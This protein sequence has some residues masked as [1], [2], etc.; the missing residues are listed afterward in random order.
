[1]T[2]LLELAELRRKGVAAETILK[3]FEPMVRFKQRGLLSRLSQA[4]PKL[5]D[6]LV[7]QA[8]AKLLVSIMASLQSLLDE[9]QK[10]G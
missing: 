2:D 3:V 6:F 5:E 9:A 7:L 4:A 1:M 10:A 8:E